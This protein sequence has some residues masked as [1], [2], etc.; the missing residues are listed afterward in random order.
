MAHATPPIDPTLAE[1]ATSALRDVPDFPTPGI[2]FKDITPLLA[3]G[4]L[5]ADVT[6]GMAAP[7]AGQGVTHVAGVESRGFILGAA[8]AL[9]LGVGLVTIRKPGT[10]PS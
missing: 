6:R 4:L 2:L 9:Q 8:V 3:D 1:R 5:L 7:F 10:L